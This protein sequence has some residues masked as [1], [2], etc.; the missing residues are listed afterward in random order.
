[1]E[2]LLLKYT[3]ELSNK[4]NLLGI[5]NKSPVD[6][7]LQNFK[8][9]DKN[10][11]GFCNYSSFI[12]VNKKLGIILEPQEF[13]K[14]FFYYDTTNEEVINYKDLINDLFN[15]N[16][17]INDN[18]IE[19]N[20]HILNNTSDIINKENKNIPPNKKPFFE[21]M[22]NNLINN[23]LGPGVNLLILYQGFILGDK[24]Y[25][26]K[27]TLNEF[28]KIMNDNNI[29]L[30]IS[31]IQMLFHSYNLNNEGFFYYEEMFEDLIN[32]YMNNQRIKILQKKAEEIMNKLNKNGKI[33]IYDL[34]NHIFIPKIYSN[35]FYN[36]LSIFDANEYYNELIN[37]YLGIKRILNYPRDSLLIIEIIEDLLKYISFG[38]QNNEDFIKALDFIFF[39]NEDSIMKD[40]NNTNGNLTEKN[41]NEI[42]IWSNLRKSFVELGINNFLNMIDYFNQNDTNNCVNKNIFIKIMK[43]FNININKDLFKNT[44]KINHTQFI[45]ELIDK[46]I[47]KEIIDIIENFYNNI[48][49]SCLNITGKTLNFNFFI[50]FSNCG[51]LFEKFHSIFYDKYFHTNNKKDIYDIINNKNIFIEKAEFI[52]FYKFQYFFTDQINFNEMIH[53]QWKKILNNKNESKTN[54]EPEVIIKLKSKLKQRGI[55]GLMNLHKEF[56]I[57]CKDLSNISFNDFIKVF[58]NQRLSLT[59]EELIKIFNLFKISPKKEILNF[60]KF[61]RVFK[62][63]LNK[64]RLNIIQNTFAKLDIN[65]NNSV[66]IS[67]IK[68]NFNAKDDIRIIKGEKNEEEIICEFLDCFDLNYYCLNNREYMG[69]NQKINF[70]EFA[71]FYE[72][73]SFIYDKDEDFVKLISN[74]WNIFE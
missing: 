1:M 59:N 17:V 20:N 28:V 54:K 69:N 68:K 61:M 37:K 58:N 32:K 10:S 64:E 35:F 67:F 7:L 74:S 57:S 8:Y 66:D 39:G 42:D 12:K 34:N 4:I 30:S 22:I 63:A 16:N 73:V 2:D 72:Y 25:R 36:K 49:I 3:Y 13:Q 27:L 62:K 71:N 24:N 26:K 33:K 51:K 47:T 21:K 48:N 44:N 43:D 50:Q 9:F 18:S 14:I 65:N 31:D 46:F 70:E 56:I 53:N 38:I 19:N 52:W 29:N 41:M 15:S 23:E 60:T 5:R 40:I 45:C 11:T 6:I 55:R